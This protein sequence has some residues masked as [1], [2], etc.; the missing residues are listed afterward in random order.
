MWVV[1]AYPMM[2]GCFLWLLGKYFSGSQPINVIQLFLHIKLE[3]E[4]E[5]LLYTSPLKWFYIEKEDAVLYVEL[6]ICILTGGSSS[7]MWNL[8]SFS[9]DM[10]SYP[11]AMSTE[12]ERGDAS[13]KTCLID[14][15]RITHG[16]LAYGYHLKHLKAYDKYKTFTK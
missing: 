11:T 10:R 1:F 9:V 14:R 3:Q 8:R 4:E 5:F 15:K 16:S 2:L 13:Q 12:R 7:E 6:C